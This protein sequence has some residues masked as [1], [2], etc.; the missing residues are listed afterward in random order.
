MIKKKIFIFTSNRSEYYILEPLIERFFKSKIFDLTILISSSHLSSKYGKTINEINKK[1]HRKLIDNK[2]N[3]N[4]EKL[5]SSIILK[6][7]KIFIENKPSAII[8]L[9]DRQEALAI[10]ISSYVFRIPIIHIHGGEKTI[11]SYDDTNRH[12]ITKLSNLH[13]CT[14]NKYRKRILQLG[15]QNKHIFNF[16]YLFKDNLTKI[17]KENKK[18]F[19][20]KT[21]LQTSNF[22]LL[23]I[24]PT[25]GGIKKNQDNIKIIKKLCD[26][27]QLN[28]KYSILITAPA[29]E[30]SSSVIFD[31]IKENKN[32]SKFTYIANLGSSLFY[33][34]I[35]Q[36]EFIVGNSSSIFTESSF[37][38]TPS[39]N[40]GNRQQG[41]VI[42]KNIFNSNYKLKDI[43]INIEY[44][45]KFNKRYRRLWPKAETSISKKIYEK[46]SSILMKNNDLNKLK[47]FNDQ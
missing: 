38:Q 30:K 1:Y 24:H 3:E 44:C 21:K 9:G 8:L 12:V 13:F 40:I 16:G 14:E 39:I 34:A 5:F 29:N 43:M 46:I 18:Q 15:E 4:N 36:C 25:D 33:N 20:S 41:R 45:K 10:A 37:F 6:L 7:E 28:L 22:V 23:L 47:V 35:Y 32:N 2:S 26:Y 17:K 27:L 31:F 42:K 19:I 11:G